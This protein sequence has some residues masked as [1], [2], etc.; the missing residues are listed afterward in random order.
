MHYDYVVTLKRENARKTD[1]VSILLLIFSIL[2]FIYVQISQGM[3]GFM[4]IAAIIL[5][6]GLG[7]NFYA[8][9]KGKEMRFRNWLFAAALFWL[10]M[11]FFQ[12]MFIPFLFFGLLEAQAKYP[13]EIG[14]H[15]EGVV[16]NSLF[17]KK[18]PWNSFQSVILKD[19]LLTLDF[20]NNKIFQ[21]EVL[22]DEEPDAEEDEFN[23]YCRS[24]LVNL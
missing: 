11:P 15:A 18:F 10:G 1:L 23:D 16:L 17:K 6:T 19:G 8:L 22:D 7:M 5:L 24:K 9:R 4:S 20:S 14:F 13:L 12:W 21:K 2:V 3:N